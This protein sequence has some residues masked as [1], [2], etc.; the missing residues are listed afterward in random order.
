MHSR[1]GPG[2]GVEDGGQGEED[3]AD[4][5]DEQEDPGARFRHARL[6][7]AHDRDVSA[8]ENK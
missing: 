6:Q 8:A 2:A 7:G 3:A 4:P 1:K 5:D